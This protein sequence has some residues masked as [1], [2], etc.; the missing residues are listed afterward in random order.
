METFSWQGFRCAYEVYFRDKTTQ[1]QPPLLLIHPIGVGLSGQFWQPLVQL[2]QAQSPAQSPA[3]SLAHTLYIPDLL[4]CG[5]SDMPRQAITPQVWAQQ[6]AYLLQTVIREPT[7]IVVQGA[8]LPV[9]LELMKIPAA[10]ALVQKLVLSGPPTLYLLTQTIP[11]WQQQLNWRLFDSPL[12]WAFFQYARTRLFLQSFSTRQLFARAEDVSET[13]L[14]ML[15]TGAQN[16][17]SRHA[18]F[19]FLA[20]FWRQDYADIFS[21]IQVPTLIVMGES[22]STIDRKAKQ[23]LQTNQTGEEKL[24]GYLK[25]FSTAQGIMVPGRNVVPYESTEAFMKALESFLH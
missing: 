16:A 3:Q 20:G 14:S 4:G 5:Q 17:A 10:V 2:W 18:V 15:E 23:S 6:M 13:W 12:G 22:A 21:Q 1:P 8:S 25:L 11:Q 19:S 7:V 24:K 9:V